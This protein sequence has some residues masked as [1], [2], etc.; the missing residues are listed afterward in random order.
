[1]IDVLRPA[2]IGAIMPYEIQDVIGLKALERIVSA[3]LDLAETRAIN[4]Q[5]MN[6]KD[7]EFFQSFAIQVKFRCSKQNKK[8]KAS[9]KSFGLCRINYLSR[10]LTGF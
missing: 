10:I 9:T 5:V 1:M 6:M 3:Y 2:T 8:P 4:R 7:W